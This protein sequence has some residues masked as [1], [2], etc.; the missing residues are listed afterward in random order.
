M[1]ATVY[2]CTGSTCRKKKGT[3]KKL[4]SALEPVA[5]VKRVK[6]Q[7]ICKGPVVGIQNGAP[8]QWFRSCGD[9]DRKDLVRVAEG[10]K[11]SK[12]LRKRVAS[13]RDGKLR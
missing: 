13:K 7:K 5:S 11:P 9:D 2:I 4:A 8:V 1:K 3:A 10:H 6:C 12:S